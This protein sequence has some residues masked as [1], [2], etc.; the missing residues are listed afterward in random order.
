M[1]R[2]HH[3]K[4]RII[5]GELRTEQLVK[6]LE[7]TESPK[8]VFLAEDGSGIVKKVTHDSMSNQLVGLVLPINGTTGM[9]LTYTYKADSA[10]NIETHLAQPQSS[11]VYIITAQPLKKGTP[12][13]ILLAFGTDNKF[14]TDDVLKRWMFTIDEL[15]RFVFPSKFH[16]ILNFMCRNKS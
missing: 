1:N 11:L 5:E 12:P 10:K 6:Y 13:F 9:P 16:L 14:K 2:L 3:E 8:V 7:K 15:Q 4:E